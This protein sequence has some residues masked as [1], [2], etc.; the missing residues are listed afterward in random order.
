MEY[1]IFDKYKEWKKIKKKNWKECLKE[2]DSVEKF[3][4][5]GIVVSTLGGLIGMSKSL[6]NFS[7]LMFLLELIFVFIVS[8]VSPSKIHKYNVG[9]EIDKKDEEYYELRV[10]LQGL[11]FTEKNMIK[12]LCIRY[13]R[14]IN[15][16]IEKYKSYKKEL[17]MLCN[18]ILFPTIIAVI[19]VILNSNNDFSSKV[20]VALYLGI[21]GIILYPIIISS[22]GPVYWFLNRNIDEMDKMVKEFRWMLDRQFVIE[23][24]DFN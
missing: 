3:L 10:F 24:S 16:R 23:E 9:I 1:I 15:D 4:L 21:I 20:S 12:K 5:G 18:V 7:V 6:P 19:T 17:K 2:L 13:E 22:I 14:I 8:L 11:G